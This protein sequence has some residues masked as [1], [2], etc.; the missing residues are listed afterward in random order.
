MTIR[1]F[2][3]FLIIFFTKTIESTTC[4][5]TLD[6]SGPYTDLNPITVTGSFSGFD[7]QN[8]L[9]LSIIQG[10]ATITNPVVTGLPFLGTFSIVITPS[11]YGSITVKALNTTGLPPCDPLSAEQTYVFNNQIPGTTLALS[12]SIGEKYSCP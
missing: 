10:A 1:L 5:L 3:L 12:E 6:P 11:S 9:V 7:A 4:S 2:L 8:F